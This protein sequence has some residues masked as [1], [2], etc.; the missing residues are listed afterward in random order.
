V[1][2]STD[3]NQHERSD[4]G[5]PTVESEIGY[6]DETRQRRNVICALAT[7]VVG[8]AF[9]RTDAS[10]LPVAPVAQKGTPQLSAAQ[11]LKAGR[12]SMKGDVEGALRKLREPVPVARPN[13]EVQ[14]EQIAPGKFLPDRNTREWQDILERLRAMG[15]TFGAGPSFDATALQL[16]DEDNPLLTQGPQTVPHMHYHGCERLLDEASD[17][18]ERALLA[19]AEWRDLSAKAFTVA[20]EVDEYHKLDEIHQ[21]EQAAGYYEV[22]AR[23]SAAERDAASAEQLATA[24]AEKAV[25]R[26]LEANCSENVIDNF[27]AYVVAAAGVTAVEPNSNQDTVV[28]VRGSQV[29][30][31]R[32]KW[33]E[34]GRR[35]EVTRGISDQVNQ[36]QIQRLFEGAITI[37]YSHRLRGLST[38]A[39]WDMKDVEFRQRRTAVARAIADRK[40]AALVDP[41]GALAFDHH[42][43]EVGERVK[44]DRSAGYARLVTARDGL[45]A[46]YGYSTSAFPQRA[47][48]DG[49]LAWARAAIDFVVRL[50]HEETAA[51]RTFSLRKMLPDP[52][53]DTGRRLGAWS[54]TLTASDF[55]P[56]LTLRTRGLSLFTYSRTPAAR[57]PIRQAQVRLPRSGQRNFSLALTPETVDQSRLATAYFGRVSV[58]SD[59]RP[60]ELVTGPAVHNASPVG[61]WTINLGPPVDGLANEIDD[62]ELE[63]HVVLVP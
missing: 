34:V 4:S 52:E 19:R 41:D 11:A 33:A 61:T 57:I 7:A 21:L 50:S 15:G 14:A 25:A 31:P 29:R 28:D 62:V 56:G 47:D 26:W 9:A 54:L 17:H 20:Q 63:V 18:F 42:R 46:V 1:R 10:Q 22:A 8:V 60:A 2:K 13:L 51:L 58:R 24:E 45:R 53:W 16:S 37:A 39:E 40:A 3:Q 35:H 32:S 30:L 5:E 12:I 23:Q 36:L 6:A 38:R 44:R 27:V 59:L 43:K 55:P 49:C 48:L